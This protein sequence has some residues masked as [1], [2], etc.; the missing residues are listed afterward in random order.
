M[1]PRPAGPAASAR[2][3]R[4]L[5]QPVLAPKAPRARHPPCPL[6]PYSWLRLP[7]RGEGG[8][9]GALYRTRGGDGSYLGADTGR[10][11]GRRCRRSRPEDLKPSR[12]EQRE[13]GQ[14]KE[15]DEEKMKKGSEGKKRK[16][17]RR[18]SKM[19]PLPLP[20]PP[21]QPGSPRSPSVQPSLS[22]APAA[23]PRPSRPPPLV[24]RDSATAAVSGR[25]SA[26]ATPPAAGSPPPCG[27]HQGGSFTAPAKPRPHAVL[28]GGGGLLENFPSTTTS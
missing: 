2:W 4:Q 22:T 21:S 1:T 27:S 9:R 6:P 13:T 12:G 16:R 28:G 5:G 24:P 18:G 15:E 7:A 23:P 20:P 8:S 3:E 11:R 10:T 14:G 25:G 26:A 17:R 19:L